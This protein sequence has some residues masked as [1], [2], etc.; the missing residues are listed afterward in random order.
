MQNTNTSTSTNPK[1][2]KL[3]ASGGFGCVFSPALKCEGSNKREKNKIS[4]LMV[5]KYAMEEYK[6]LMNIKN[7]LKDI[8]N[9]QDYFLIEDITLCKPTKLTK[10]DLTNLNKCNILKKN[11]ITKK[12]I[13]HSLSDLLA[14]NMPYGGVTIEKFITNVKNYNKI[15]IVNDGLIQLLKNAIVKMNSK[16]IYNSDIKASN[17]L[18]NTKEEIRLIDWSLIVEYVPFKN[19]RFPDNW[20]NRPLQFNVPFSIILFTDL[21][22][23]SYSKFVKE[24]TGIKNEINEYDLNSF[25]RNYFEDWCKERGLGHFKYINKIMYMLFFH[26]L[27]GNE[28]EHHTQTRDIKKY[29]E[30][31]YTLPYIVNYLIQILI[32]FTKFKKDGSLNL[33]DYLD[34]VFIKIVDVW[35]FVVSYLPLYELFFENY[36]NLTKH[37]LIIMDKLKHIFLTYLY[38]PR[39][40]PIPLQNLEKDLKELN[41]YF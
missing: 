17:I 29:I 35:G 32:H 11:N 14:V 25:V 34:N 3:I 23:E 40:K 8:P 18:V 36:D 19:N 27:N 2:G 13:N 41:T 22:V 12:N 15:T 24:R 4:K 7:K 39:I 10:T 26:D 6:E 37:Q 21:F 31:K 16:N 38:E 30:N 28:N 1:G 20:R 33:R 5:N 9:Y